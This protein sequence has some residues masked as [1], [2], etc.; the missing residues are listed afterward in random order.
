MIITF[1]GHRWIKFK[2]GITLSIFNGFGSYSENHFNY[3]VRTKKIIKTKTCEI[4]ILRNEFF[5][6]DSILNNGDKVK[7]YVNKKELKEIIQKIKNYGMN[8][9]KNI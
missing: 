4:A 5:I 8:N 9:E 3:K 2:N 6:T 7:G 1:K